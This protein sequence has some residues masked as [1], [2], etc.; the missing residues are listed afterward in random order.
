MK[1]RNVRNHSYHTVSLSKRFNRISHGFKRFW[2]ESPKPLIDKNTIQAHS[3]RGLLHLFTQ[4]ESE[5]E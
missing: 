4:F 2:I 3:A 1:F 5:R